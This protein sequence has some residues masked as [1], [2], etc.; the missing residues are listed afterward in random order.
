LSGLLARWRKL[1]ERKQ[2]LIAAA[3]LVL[4]CTGIGALSGGSSSRPKLDERAHIFR[5]PPQP[6]PK[7][8]PQPKPT[9]K[10]H[11][12]LQPARYL[13]FEDPHSTA[14]FMAKHLNSGQGFDRVFYGVATP[15]EITLHGN[16][17]GS[18]FDLRLYKLGRQEVLM[19]N[20]ML[21]SCYSEWAGA[22]A[23]YEPPRGEAR[24]LLHRRVRAGVLRL[25]RRSGE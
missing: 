16:L 4:A 8:E 21:G 22:R 20:C 14:E 23:G 13:H 18:R 15:F 17:N 12:S 2:W 7:L 10:P 9:P 11:D 24:L 3:A 25:G 19:K 1:P 5:P 6:K